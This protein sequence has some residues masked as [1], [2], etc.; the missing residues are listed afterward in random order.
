MA[1]VISTYGAT[2]NTIMSKVL[3]QQ[4]RALKI[5]FHLKRKETVHHLFS[6]LRILLVYGLYIN[7]SINN[8]L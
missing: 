7:L 3:L 2:T 6:D 5:I 1:S 8:V 4:K